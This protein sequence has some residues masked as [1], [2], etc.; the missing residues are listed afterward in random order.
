MFINKLIG[1]VVA[2]AV[3]A[4]GLMLASEQ[5]QAFRSTKQESFTDPDYIGYRPATVVIMVI[6]EDGETR[7]E[8]EKRLTKE[9]EKLGIVV[10]RQIDLFPPTR[11]WSEEAQLEIYDKHKIEAGLI[12]TVGASSSSVIPVATQTNSS[13]NVFGTYNNGYVNAQGTSSSTSYNI[14]NAKSKAQFSAVLL[15]LRAN[16]VAWYVD[17]FTKAQ[18]TLFVGSKGDAKAAVK[19]IIE[20]LEEDGH[21]GNEK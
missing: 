13:T 4:T 21:V 15:D 10:Y 14:Y 7:M 11:E 19:G 20:G 2:L 1:P 8:I 12:A 16:R 5:V 3:L 9:L 17:V 6:A 18:G